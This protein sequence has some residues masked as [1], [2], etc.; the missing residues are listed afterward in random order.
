MTDH[1]PEGDIAPERITAEK[2]ALRIRWATDDAHES[3][4]PLSFLTRAAYDP[5][6]LDTAPQQ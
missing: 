4:F 5:P 3:L 2:G 1:Q 6:V